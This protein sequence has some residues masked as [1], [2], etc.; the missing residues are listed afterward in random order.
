MAMDSQA[1]LFYVKPTTKSEYS[2]T[3]ISSRIKQLIERNFDF[4]RIK[5]E[6][7]GF[8]IAPSGHAYFT[9]KDDKS[10]LAAVCW[11]GNLSN[12]KCKPEEGMEVICTG[13]I[14]T[15]SGQSKYQLNVHSIESSG[16]GALMAL[17]EKR[18]KQFYAEGLFDQKHKKPLPFLPTTIG[19]VTSITGAVIRDIIHRISDRFPVRIIIWPVL[20]QGP[21]SAEQIAKAIQGFNQLESANKPN[22]IIVARGGGSIE[23]LWS[24]NEEIVVRAAFNSIIPIISAVGHETDTSLLDFVAD[25]RAPTPTAAA[26]MAVPVRQDLLLSLEEL[27]YRLSHS[28]TKKLEQTSNE[29]TSL[30]RALPNLNKVVFEYEQRLDELTERLREATIR[31]CE[32]KQNRVELL[33]SKITHPKQMLEMAQNKIDMY[34]HNLNYA[35]QSK[36]SEREMTL[37]ATISLY[38]SYSYEKTLQRG[39]AVVRGHNNHVVK[40]VSQFHKAEIYSLRVADGEKLIKLSD[41]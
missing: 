11:R 36:L 22:I 30:S 28:L 25:R 32:L 5:G 24:F 3:E 13:S 16:V 2:V 26:E 7:S 39:F 31:F 23:D 34:W 8:K 33:I 35:M 1:D 15:Y 37:K 12:L 40:S 38:D 6:I 19:V 41:S 4:V 29:L 9:L 18:K 14:T 27:H 21:D 17:L 10:V 20:V